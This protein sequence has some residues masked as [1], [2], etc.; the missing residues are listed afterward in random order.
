M[1]LKSK[2]QCTKEYMGQNCHQCDA[3]RVNDGM[4]KVPNT[5]TLNTKCYCCM[6]NEHNPTSCVSVSITVSD[7]S[8]SERSSNGAN[9]LIVV[10]FL[11]C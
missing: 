8:L 1:Q 10:L 11:N 4:T 6:N 9:A 5:L 2:I 3:A 7:L